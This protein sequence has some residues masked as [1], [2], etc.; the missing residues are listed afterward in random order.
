MTRSV[1]SAAS[2]TSKSL[3]PQQS[4]VILGGIGTG[5]FEIWDDGGFYL[6]QIF[7]N[8]TF[9][10]GR[11]RTSLTS[12]MPPNGLSFSI[13]TRA[14]SQTGLWKLQ[15][16]NHK[17]GEAIEEIYHV[18][19]LRFPEAINYY[20]RQ[21]FA[22]LDYDL[23]NCPLQVS[24]EAFT[25]FIVNSLDDSAWP[26]AIFRVKLKNITDCDVSTAVVGSLLN[27]TPFNGHAILRSHDIV[28][29]ENN[30]TVYFEPQTENQTEDNGSMAFSVLGPEKERSYCQKWSA[31]DI[32]PG[33]FWA[34]FEKNN[35]LNNNDSDLALKIRLAEHLAKL[36][37]DMNLSQV[38]DLSKL[39]R[40]QLLDVIRQF[41]VSTPLENH[42]PTYLNPSER[43][44]QARENLLLETLLRR[45]YGKE[46][47]YGSIARTVYL[48]AS[49]EI[50]VEFKLA[51][52]FPYHYT[53]PS[54][55]CGTKTEASI[56][57]SNEIK[58]ID[59]KK[60]Y[61]G[62]RYNKFG[63]NALE[64]S[65]SF[66]AVSEDLEF[67]TREFVNA[68]YESSLP[69]WL[70]DAINAQLTSIISNSWYTEDGRFS[71]WPGSGCCGCSEIGTGFFATVPLILFYPEATKKQLE[72]IMAHQ[73]P[74]GRFPHAFAGNFDETTVYYDDNCLKVPIQVYRDWLWTADEDYLQRMWPK[75]LKVMDVCEKMDLDGDRIPDAK[76]HN[77]DYDQWMFFGLSSYFASHWPVTLRSMVAMGEHLG[78]HKLAQQWAD[79][80][81]AA[82]KV[83][84]SELW[85]GDYYALYKDQ[86]NNIQSNALLANNLCGEWYARLLGMEPSLPENRIKEN[87]QSVFKLNRMEGI[88]LKGGWFPEN[89]RR[90]PGIRD[91]HWDVCWLGAEYAA[92]SHMIYEGLLEEGLTVCKEGHQRHVNQ[93]VRYNHFEC[94]E[95]Y[96]RALTIWSVLTALQGF[97]WDAVTKK[98]TFIPKIEVDNHK[99]VIVL[100]QGWAVA[101]Q[102]LGGGKQFFKLAVKSGTIPLRK[103]S[104]VSLA[105]RVCIAGRDLKFKNNQHEIIFDNDCL[106]EKGQTLKI[107]LKQTTI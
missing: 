96:T 74:D 40:E 71:L 42:L 63:K 52:S 25:P 81:D 49:E 62:H 27:C 20:G 6:W 68:L 11:F 26:V 33:Q 8:G 67:S 65:Q 85:T 94:G 76:G 64:I 35:Q 45:L 14:N 43:T 41:P 55:K 12:A 28:H 61:V 29:K 3:L 78:E 22:R 89:E 7:N 91:W 39:D 15:M 10:Q 100:P 87:L 97:K 32:S 38:S 54:P 13:R 59:V 66:S 46:P 105:E 1:W 50:E 102:K 21:P 106:L 98:L 51:W 103:F 34:Q 92:A 58:L 57:S 73:I 72:M 107:T 56:E 9:Q 60:T 69:E 99:S 24:L 31:T 101:E 86:R 84:D 90:E 70:S 2:A 37:L 80:A 44:P 104:L 77:Q 30:T 82:T 36:N 23:G 88:G 83:I 19:E 16:P 17:L 48:K 75:L 95:H 93:G 79:Q 18:P 53:Y 4:G 47:F 5:G